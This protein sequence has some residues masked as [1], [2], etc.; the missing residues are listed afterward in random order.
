MTCIFAIKGDPND[1]TVAFLLGLVYN[2]PMKN[3][4]ESGLFCATDKRNC[5]EIIR[6]VTGNRIMFHI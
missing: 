5:R 6:W 4:E 2:S 1:L 3:V